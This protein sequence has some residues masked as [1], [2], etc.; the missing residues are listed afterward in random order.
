MLGNINFLWRF[1]SNSAGKINHFSPLLK[2]QGEKEFIWEPIHQKAFDKIKSYLAN[3]SVLVP[4]RPKVPLKLYISASENSI[5]SLLAQDE[6]KE[7]GKTV[8]HAIFYLSKTLLDA[9]KW[10]LLIEKL[11]L[12]VYFFGCKLCH[13]MLFIYYQGRGTN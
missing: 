10:Y 5:A 8:E 3:P 13:Y 4:P 11:C 1:I 7:D 2:L 12:A 9:E 6:E